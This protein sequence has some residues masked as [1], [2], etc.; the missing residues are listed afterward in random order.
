MERAHE[1]VDVR[2]QQVQRRQRS[3]WGGGQD[4]T[5][6]AGRGGRSLGARAG[7]DGDRGSE[8]GC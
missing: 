2:A 8:R 6:G 3:R 7:A 1:R 5:H 4:D